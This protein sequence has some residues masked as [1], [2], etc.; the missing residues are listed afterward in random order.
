MNAWDVLPAVGVAT[1][2]LAC[3]VRF[4]AVMTKTAV[5]D[6]GISRWLYPGAIVF[7]VLMLWDDAVVQPAWLQMLLF[8]VAPFV[9]G[10]GAHRLLVKQR[11]HRHPPVGRRTDE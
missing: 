11:Q 1:V 8:L 2:A 7:G 10:F 5:D 3:G 6:F 9:L 4:S